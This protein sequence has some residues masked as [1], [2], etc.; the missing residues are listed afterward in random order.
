MDQNS[1]NQHKQS[2]EPVKPD[3]NRNRI[4]IIVSIA[5]LVVGAAAGIIFYLIRKESISTGEFKDSA[6]SFFP[7]IP[8]WIAIFIPSIFRKKKQNANEKQKRAMIITAIL[9]LILVLAGIAAW[10][11]YASR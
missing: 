1:E 8:I 6:R 7:F 10:Y 4:T 3:N 9:S 5:L 2:M 11:Y